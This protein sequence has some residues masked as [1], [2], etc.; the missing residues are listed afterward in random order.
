[1]P[2]YATPLKKGSADQPV[3]NASEEATKANPSAPP[4][5]VSQ[6]TTPVV[7]S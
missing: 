2:V 4:T 3:G 1:M 7:G 5:E 6:E